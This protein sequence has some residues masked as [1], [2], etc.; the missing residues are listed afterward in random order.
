MRTPESS[1]AQQSSV[2][3]TGDHVFVRDL[4]VIVRAFDCTIS[5][6]RIVQSPEFVAS[7]DDMNEMHFPLTRRANTVWIATVIVVVL[8]AIG[9]TQIRHHAA[10][11]RFEAIRADIRLINS[12]TTQLASR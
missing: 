12:A 9:A 3:V 2:L 1:G 7:I 6:N 5:G 4:S 8:G 10:A 11:R